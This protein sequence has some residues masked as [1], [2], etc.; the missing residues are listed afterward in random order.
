MGVD[1]EE[2]GVEARVR[3]ICLALPKVTEKVRHGAPSFFAKGA[4]KQFVQLWPQ[5]HHDHDFPHLW[6]AAPPGAQEA[7]V[8]ISPVRFFRPPYVGHRGW[9]GVRLDGDVDWHEVAGMCED[10]YQSVLAS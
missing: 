8:A 7:L 5:G 3:A 4:K 2:G 1:G 6:C 10:G 9:V